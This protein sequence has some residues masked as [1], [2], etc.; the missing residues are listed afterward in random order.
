MLSRFKRSLW[1]LLP[2]GLTVL[3]ISLFNLGRLLDKHHP[4]IMHQLGYGLAAIILC[5]LFSLLIH[6][7]RDEPED[8]D[9]RWS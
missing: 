7:L 3:C 9:R 1:L 4:A 5:G 2:V 8:D 6:Q